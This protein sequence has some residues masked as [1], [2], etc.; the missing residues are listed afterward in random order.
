MKEIR[1]FHPT[2]T[3]HHGRKRRAEKPYIDFKDHHQIRRRIPCECCYNHKDAEKFARHVERLIVNAANSEGPS[4]ETDTWLKNLPRSALQKLAEIGLIDT[5]YTTPA[6]PLAQHIADWEYFLRNTVSKK[7]RKRDSDYVHNRVQCVRN[8]VDSPE[9]QFKSWADIS[10]VRIKLYL[11]RRRDQL[12][13]ATY[14][15]YVDSFKA[16]A[17][18]MV[19]EAH[20]A[21]QS[22]VAKL[23]SI[24]AETEAPRRSVT[25]DELCRLLGTVVH[26]PPT[27]LDSVPGVE[28]GIIYLMGAELGFRTSELRAL[29]VRDFDL[30]REKPHAFRAPVVRLSGRYTKNGKDAEQPLRR[31]RAEQ[32]AKWFEGRDP[33]SPAF[34]VPVKSNNNTRMFDRDRRAAG[35]AK[36][37]ASGLSLT[38]HSLRH[39]LATWLDR[40]GVSVKVRLAVIRH[41]VKG[42][43]AQLLLD[44]YTDPATALEKRDAV[45]RLP[46]LPWPTDLLIE[47]QERKEGVA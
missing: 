40:A 29:K 22:P 16:F 14:N 21:T 33:D 38:F 20:R 15:A 26:L 24:E 45:E 23:E 31:D 34:Q 8:I 47:A 6:V 46:T 5:R 4:V 39:S 32:L 1:I 43:E 19:D 11:G 30:D 3:D 18:W 28:R 42:R 35:I 13:S 12:A 25:S 44:T 41:S 7:G 27:D 2:Y 9:C 37:D 17:D 36:K 10:L